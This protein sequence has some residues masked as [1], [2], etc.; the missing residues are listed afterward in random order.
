MTRFDRDQVLIPQRHIALHA[1]RATWGD[2]ERNLAGPMLNF[3]DLKHT[4]SIRKGL[5]ERR[6]LGS[7]RVTAANRLGAR[8]GRSTSSRNDI[9]GV[10]ERKGKYDFTALVL[11]IDPVSEVYYPVSQIAHH[12]VA[13]G[14][15]RS[16]LHRFQVGELSA[17]GI[18]QFIDMIAQMEKVPRHENSHACRRER[19][20]LS[21]VV[22]AAE[23]TM[24]WFVTNRRS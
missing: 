6:R 21:V 8:V 18:E 11:G 24:L 3:V 9:H 10:L 19:G 23:A 4:A 12:D 5:G 17:L 13:R 22:A 14:S 2:P 7:L 16:V 15:E 20:C 1:S